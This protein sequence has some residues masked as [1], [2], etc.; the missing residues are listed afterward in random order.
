MRL[1]NISV[2]ILGHTVS[3]EGMCA[4]PKL[5]RPTH[6]S[7]VWSFLRVVDYYRTFLTDVVKM[8]GS[9]KYLLKDPDKSEKRKLTWLDEYQQAFTEIKKALQSIEM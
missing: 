1:R 8:L 5:P 3:M 7:E 6:F 4:L 2:I 9:L